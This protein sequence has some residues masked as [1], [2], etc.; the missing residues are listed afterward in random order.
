MEKNKEE[1]TII[2]K[3][4]T[5]SYKLRNTNPAKKTR[6]NSD[7]PERSAVSALQRHPSCYLV[8]NPVV[9]RDEIANCKI[10]LETDNTG[11]SMFSTWTFNLS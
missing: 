3:H 5:A 2:I 6:M 4:Y 9:S 10:V 11:W 1:N 7:S 8:K